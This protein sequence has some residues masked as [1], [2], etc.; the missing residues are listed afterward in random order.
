[1]GTQSHLRKSAFAL[2]AVAAVTWG[3]GTAGAV[4]WGSTGAPDVGLSRATGPG[5]NACSV[6]ATNHGGQAANDVIVYPLP[7]YSRATLGTIQP[8][9]SDTF[10]IY[11]CG[12]TNRLLFVAITS[13]GDS[14]WSN[15]YLYIEP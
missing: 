13:N 6:T 8:G 9:E 1:M 3:T 4:P 2:A 14:N 10:S 7:G 12:F 5:L 15:N 11:D